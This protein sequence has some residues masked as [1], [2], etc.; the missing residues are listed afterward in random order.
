MARHSASAALAIAGAAL[1]V[2]VLTGCTGS[3]SPSP[4]PSTARPVP[5]GE[6][7]TAPVGLHPDLPAAE[8]LP[9]FDQ[10]NQQVVAANAA[11][12]GRDFI[13]A[14]TAAGFDRAAMQVTSDQTT[15]GEPADSVQ[16][17]VLFNDECL[18]GQ[19]GPKSGGYHGAVKPG[20]GTGGCL[21]GQTRPIDW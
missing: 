5:T 2:A 7:T 19:Y 13:D 20:L 4:S 3:P 17:S 9:F 8:N 11:A 12:G 1:F 15:L 14:L 10:V 16:F 18:V 6:A 21:I